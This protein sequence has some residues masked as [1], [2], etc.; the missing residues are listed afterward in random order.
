MYTF[1]ASF[2]SDR[3]DAQGESKIT[4]AVPMSD[5]ETIAAIKKHFAGQSILMEVTIK[6]AE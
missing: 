4:L 1:P 2:Y 3:T 5:V 6:P